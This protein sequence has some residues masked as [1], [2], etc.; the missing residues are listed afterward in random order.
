MANMLPSGSVPFRHLARSCLSP[1]RHYPPRSPITGCMTVRLI[2]TTGPLHA[3]T[4]NPVFT[5]INP[6]EIDH[7]SRLSSE[8][9]N[10]SG[11]FS[12]LHKMNPV[13]VEYIRQKVAWDTRDEA[14]W[15]FEGR[16][17]DRKREEARGTGR[18]LSGKR[19]LDVGCGGGLL[20]EVSGVCT[21]GCWR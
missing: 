19:C 12:L 18:W 4:P 15:T 13:R 7:F 11:E 5:T 21:H 14:D 1:I 8:W 6:D 17:L 20:S 2:H 10:S 9:W 16:G 3:N